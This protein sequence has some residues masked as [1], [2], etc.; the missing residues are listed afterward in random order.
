MLNK[1]PHFRNKI[2]L[3]K[4]INLFFPKCNIQTQIS[5]K[6]L[7]DIKF[8]PSTIPCRKRTAEMWIWGHKGQP[9]GLDTAF[10][11]SEIDV[12]K[13]K[14]IE[15]C[16]RLGSQPIKQISYKLYFKGCIDKFSYIFMSCYWATFSH[17]FEKISK[18]I[19]SHYAH[20]IK[21]SENG[22]PLKFNNFHE[23]F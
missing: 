10:Q 5:F 18:A 2:S 8:L 21:E 4:V 11:D 15:T 20:Y 17:F 23:K 1:W 22:Q 7:E 12:R 14:R 16:R 3:I 13:V 9:C 6:T 19:F